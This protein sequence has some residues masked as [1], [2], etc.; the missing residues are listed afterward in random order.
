MTETPNPLGDIATQVA[1]LPKMQWVDLEGLIGCA[2]AHLASRRTPI[3]GGDLHCLSISHLGS[4]SF[5]HVYRLGFN[6]DTK[7]AASVT[8]DKESKFLPAGKESE[9]ATM[10]FVRNSGLYP[11]IPVPEVYAWDTTFKNLAGAPY[12]L[13]EVID[14]VN[15][16]TSR[17]DPGSPFIRKF[18]ILP[19]ARQLAIVK[20]LA[21]F[22]ASLSRPVPFTELGSVVGGTT[23]TGFSIGP[24]MNINHETNHEGLGGPYKSAQEMWHALQER[25]ILHVVQRWCGLE[26][27]NLH[28]PGEGPAIGL[29]PR[30]FSEMFHSLSS[31]IPH[32]A[33]P[34]PYSTLV[35]HHP[36]FALRNI[37]FDEASLASGTPKITGV[38]DWSG[39][40]ILPLMLTAVLPADL[41]SNCNTPFRP[42]YK[43][44][45]ELAYEATWRSVPYDWTSIGDPSRYPDE[46]GEWGGSRAVDYKPVLT[47]LIRRFYLRKYF[48]SCYAS[49]LNQIHGDMDLARTSLFSDAEYYLKF[50]ETMCLNLRDWS[51]MESWVRETYWRLRAKVN[52]G[53]SPPP[54]V[55][56][57]VPL[58]VGPNVYHGNAGRA[59]HD[60]RM[61][62]EESDQWGV[63]ICEWFA[64]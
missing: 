34:K 30:T 62:R 56:D 26:S 59:I 28:E 9:I 60:L 29:T 44:P 17:V 36:D 4:G 55:G 31:L 52:G 20:A 64:D 63:D 38:I 21:R 6:D 5:N 27:D 2:T 10:K 16:D 42:L 25:R 33:I 47:V 19:E 24:L 41:W 57:D 40:Q 50:H 54:G 35:L 61:L 46:N 14:G 43:N 37:L 15:V 39:A 45:P 49:H 8:K 18:D 23:K 7:I 22:K 53:T 51:F 13:M 32:F 11:D 58:V 3:P 12:V 48:G 1:Q